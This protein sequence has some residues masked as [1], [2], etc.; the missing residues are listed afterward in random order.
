[1][2]KSF[3]FPALPH[4]PD[5][6]AR[7]YVWQEISGFH[8]SALST[9]FY[10][11][12]AAKAKAL[13]HEDGF[14]WNDFPEAHKAYK[15]EARDIL[16]RLQKLPKLDTT[17]LAVTIPFFPDIIR[18]AQP[19]NAYSQGIFGYHIGLLWNGAQE[20]VLG[21]AT[22]EKTGR[23][24]QAELAYWK[25]PEFDG[26]LFRLS[27]DEFMSWGCRVGYNDFVAHIEM[28]TETQR[29][30]EASIRF[31]KSLGFIKTVVRPPNGSNGNGKFMHVLILNNRQP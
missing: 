18:L 16:F 28:K 6:E 19:A 2:R 3:Q 21:I 5:K 12:T 4:A 8:S 10:E 9:F 7:S 11:L 17:L 20:E 23:P 15:Q 14:E 29:G 13:M 25:H 26:D 27:V 22:L 31:A 24:H 1:M 30:N